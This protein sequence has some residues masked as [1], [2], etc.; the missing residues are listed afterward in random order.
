MALG[1]L[2]VRL[3][4]ED[5]RNKD[6]SIDNQ[7]SDGKEWFKKHN[8][9]LVKIYNEGFHPGDRDRKEFNAMINAA[10]N[11]FCDFILIKNETRFA[12]DAAFLIDTM[13]DLKA[14]GIKVYSFYGKEYTENP[15]VTA[16]EGV[17]AEDVP[18]KGRLSQREM[19]LRK[20]RDKGV[21]GRPPPGYKINHKIINGKLVKCGWIVDKAKSQLIKSIY[22]DYVIMQSINQVSIKYTI[23]PATINRILRNKKYVKIFEYYLREKDSNKKVVKTEKKEY[24]PDITSIVDKETFDKVQTLLNRNNTKVEIS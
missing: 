13:K 17:I 18:N 21:F 23:S 10:K 14:Y 19:M 20:D 8:H 7:L 15:L 22:Q 4:E 11:R 2:Y 16:I 6:T 9:T 1:F 5:K 12:R 3:S 24:K